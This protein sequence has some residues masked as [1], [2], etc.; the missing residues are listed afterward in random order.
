MGINVSFVTKLFTDYF[1]IML[2]K[3][4]SYSLLNVILIISIG[5]FLFVKLIF[6]K[7]SSYNDNI[8]Y[9]SPVYKF[10][11][12]LFIKSEFFKNLFLFL[13]ILIQSILLLRISN[14]LNIFD[15]NTYIAG[16][17]YLL[18]AGLQFSMNFNPIIF[19]NIFFILGIILLLKTISEKK[20]Q[21]KFFNS[22]IFFSLS[23]L[24]YT[25]YIFLF[26]LGII[27]VI[28]I[29][30]KITREIFAFLLGFFT[31]QIIF[32]EIYYL[33]EKSFFDYKL[34]L[35]DI[36]QKNIKFTDNIEFVV[37]FIIFLTFFIISSLHL[38]KTVSFKEIEKRTSYTLLFVIFVFTVVLYMIIPSIGFTFLNTFAI[39][40]TFLFGN[41]FANIQP[42][43]LNSLSFVIFTLNFIYILI[44]SLF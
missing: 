26:I 21:N 42:K 17:I 39:T 5:L 31:I 38:V 37:F 22:G 15:K 16:I 36:F 1:N 18:I 13:I 19:A 23:S 11:E 10:I 44:F 4:Q 8:I 43:R 28:L 20:S 27:A 41:Y 32:F 30:S 35:Y 29:R 34:L 33:L 24:I 40:L 3:I 2:K 14:K 7:N 6:F 25:P 9:Y 12:S